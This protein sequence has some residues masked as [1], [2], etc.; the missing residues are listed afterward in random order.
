MLKVCYEMYKIFV[1]KG[2]FYLCGVFFFGEDVCFCIL[3]IVNMC[4][5]ICIVDM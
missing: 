5:V 4:I 3:L 1:F 2:I